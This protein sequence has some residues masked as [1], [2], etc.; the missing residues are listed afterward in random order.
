[1]ALSCVVLVLFSASS[2]VCA[3][4]E[5]EVGLYDTHVATLGGAVHGVAPV[6][7]DASSVAVL[8]AHGGVALLD[9]ATGEARW[10]K[11]ALDLHAPASASASMRV[12]VARARVL[13][14]STRVAEVRD[15]AS[16]A[17][18]WRHLSAPADESEPFALALSR[19]DDVLF[20]WA[21]GALSAVALTP[22][23]AS[24]VASGHSLWS[25]PTPLPAGINLSSALVAVLSSSYHVVV[26]ASLSN[27]ALWFAVFD[28]ATGAAVER[29]R[30]LA[31]PDGRS[32]AAAPLVLV[33]G[34]SLLRA[35]DV[36][37]DLLFQCDVSQEAASLEIVRR[38][39]GAHGVR[40]VSSLGGSSPVVLSAGVESNGDDVVAVSIF[41]ASASAPSESWRVLR[42]PISPHDAAPRAGVRLLSAFVTGG[43]AALTRD[44]LRIVVQ[45]ADDVLELYDGHGALLWRRHEALAAARSPFFVDLPNAVRHDR[46]PSSWLERIAWQLQSLTS[47]LAGRTAVSAGSGGDS[48][49]VRDKFAFEK[50]LLVRSANHRLYA[51]RA[52]TGAVLWSR[53]FADPDTKARLELLD[54]RVLHAATISGAAHGG[55]AVLG[56]VVRNG[57]SGRLHSGTIEAAHGASVQALQAL[58]AVRGSVTFPKSAQWV[59]VEAGDERARVHV[60]GAQA[61]ARAAAAVLYHVQDGNGTVRGLR[62]SSPD[63]VQPGQSVIDLSEQW[64]FAVPPSQQVV[65]RATIDSGDRVNQAVRVLQN[66]TALYK[67]TDANRLVVVTEDARAGLLHVHVIDTGS[68][69]VAHHAVL[70]EAGAPVLA[71]VTEHALAISYRNLKQR[72]FDLLVTELYEQTIDW[73]RDAKVLDGAKRAAPRVESRT[74][75]LPERVTALAATQTAHG[76]AHRQWL[77]ALESGR[78]YAVPRELLDVGVE[79]AP[80]PDG[81]PAMLPPQLALVGL[82]V[83]SHALDLGQPAPTAIAVSP[84]LLESTCVAA[85]T[86]GA[87]GVFVWRA[88]PSG[89][90][91]VLSENFA[92][93]SLIATIVATVV[94]TLVVRHLAER[95]AV[96]EQWQ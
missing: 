16:G 20:S 67:Y 34:S 33:D 40:Q 55:A 78:V 95:K 81:S 86:G 68:G 44:S 19:R 48:A 41:G 24:P 15:A 84:T 5:S 59:V 25:S 53:A 69:R 77:M 38:L 56:V 29:G 88:A 47:L 65:A 94:A 23:A 74:L 66:M 32:L 87:G 92:Y 31:P 49:L 90:F 18:L 43:K 30:S 28:A 62:A 6:S 26:A 71:A 36:S 3:L 27:G 37:G 85:A 83:A 8:T 46:V 45:D 14:Q 4:L 51:L 82:H 79:A 13:L 35:L 72:R 93:S 61:D 9:T 50:L 73:S 39:Q 80:M 91:D 54:V 1:M 17:V 42:A 21:N 58:P 60:L 76:V 70:S 7:T 52:S 89:R 75:A 11:F 10:R 57:A 63:A 64:R 96:L 12:S 2:L 22:A